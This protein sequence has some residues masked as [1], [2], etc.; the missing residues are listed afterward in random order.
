MQQK[1]IDCH[2]SASANSHNDDNVNFFND[3]NFSYAKNSC[4]TEGV[5]RSI[6]KSKNVSRDISR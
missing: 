5:A 1:N 4:H 2:E 6:S 3:G